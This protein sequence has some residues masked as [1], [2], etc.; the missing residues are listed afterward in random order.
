MITSKNYNKD[1]GIFKGSK[2]VGFFR[3][4]ATSLKSGAAA[5]IAKV[6]CS[7]FAKPV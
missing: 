4:F 7:S 3:L 6:L 1:F 5:P 2:G